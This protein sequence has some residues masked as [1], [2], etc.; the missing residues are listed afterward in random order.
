MDDRNEPPA[1]G[2]PDDA[3]ADPPDVDIDF[4]DKLDR[5]LRWDGVEESELP[6]SPRM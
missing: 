5:G 6:R 3:S 1:P 4:D 2:A